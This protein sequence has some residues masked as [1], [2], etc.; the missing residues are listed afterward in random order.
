[1]E[2]KDQHKLS[3]RVEYFFT[4][5]F[6]KYFDWKHLVEC[7]QLDIIK[8]SIETEPHWPTGLD[9]LLSFFIFVCRIHFDCSLCFSIQHFPASHRNK[10]YQHELKMLPCSW[11]ALQPEEMFSPFSLILHL[12]I[13]VT[14]I[15][16]IYETEISLMFQYFHK[17]RVQMEANSQILT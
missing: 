1:M 12:Y 3:K 13:K 15:A 8:Y 5:S 9:P 7:C 10:R 14:F 17:S 4:S 16:A 11:F 6:W 2:K